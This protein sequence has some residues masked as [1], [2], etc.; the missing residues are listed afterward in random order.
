L[1]TKKIL[2]LALLL[3]SVLCARGQAI[4]DLDL[5]RVE[6]KLPGVSPVSIAKVIDARADKSTIGWLN[7]GLQN[8]RLLA[9]F[10]NGLE[11]DLT[12]FLT[13]NLVHLPDARPVVMR[14]QQLRIAERMN[15]LSETATAELEADFFYLHKD[16]Y[17]FLVHTAEAAQMT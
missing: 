4:Y 5:T 12:A 11:P 15:H 8:T 9:R 17:H 2:S 10:R 13:K 7:K 14:V 16:G 3:L 6:T 1:F